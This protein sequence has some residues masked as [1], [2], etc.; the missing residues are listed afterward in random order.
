MCDLRVMIPS[1]DLRNA[2][3]CL[4]STSTASILPRPTLD[5]VI[6]SGCRLGDTVVLTL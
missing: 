2:F 3:S 4:F 6:L 5:C 1:D